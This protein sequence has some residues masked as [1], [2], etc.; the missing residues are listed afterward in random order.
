MSQN[1]YPYA[2]LAGTLVG[3][4]RQHRQL[5]EDVAAEGTIKVPDPLPSA[6]F[7]EPLVYAFIYITRTASLWYP[8]DLVT[9]LL[10]ELQS[11]TASFVAF[12][13][14]E[15]Q[16][17]LHAGPG[18]SGSFFGLW[19]RHE[20]RVKE[21]LGKCVVSRMGEYA[22]FSARPLVRIANE[23]GASSYADRIFLTNTVVQLFADNDV[24]ISRALPFKFAGIVVRHVEDAFDAFTRT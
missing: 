6:L 21:L 2:S 17:R 7:F 20:E 11:A 10:V 22:T 5:F 14:P 19:A 24:K 18:G 12:Y 15:V 3:I 16:E 13:H 23:L 4:A 1:E 9:R 8:T